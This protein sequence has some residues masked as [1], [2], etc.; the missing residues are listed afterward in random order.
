M[1]GDPRLAASGLGLL[2]PVRPFGR[3]VDRDCAHI[4]RQR[5]F[6]DLEIVRGAD[7]LVEHA[8]G[9]EDRVA[10][11]QPAIR[12]V[13]EFELDP[14]LQRVDELSL[15]NMVMPASRLGHSGDRRRYLRP[16]PPVSRLRDAEVAV[17]EEIT[18]PLDE[19]WRLRTRH[20]ELRR[21]LRLGRLFLESRLLDRHAET[22]SRSW[23]RDHNSICSEAARAA[24]TPPENWC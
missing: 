10:G 16:H 1:I 15:A 21:R 24:F 4:R 20:R 6:E 3:R 11:L 14:A 12:A 13:L 2:R 22:S 5:D 7:L 17:F 23:C 9:D 8:A 18:P 19:L